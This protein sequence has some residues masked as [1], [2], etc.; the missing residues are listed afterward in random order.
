MCSGIHSLIGAAL[1][2]WDNWEC[3]KPAIVRIM[4]DHRLNCFIGI[5]DRFHINHI[6]D[7]DDED[8]WD[9]AY[10]GASEQLKSTKA[11]GY[12]Y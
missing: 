9:E 1:D 5:E 6:M 2:G 3:L 10:D 4:S 7:A 11:K 12:A 8:A